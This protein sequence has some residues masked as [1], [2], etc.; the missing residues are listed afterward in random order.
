METG[1]GNKHFSGAT[2]QNQKWES[3]RRYPVESVDSNSKAQNMESSAPYQP[4][5]AYSHGGKEETPTEKGRR[6]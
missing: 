4:L 6:K 2:M 3:K 5:S 1:L